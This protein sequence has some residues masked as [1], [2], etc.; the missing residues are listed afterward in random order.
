MIDA[1]DLIVGAMASGAAAGLKVA[2]KDTIKVAYAKLRKLITKNEHIESTVRRLEAK[3]SDADA[4]AALHKQ[5]AELGLEKRS[6]ARKA[7]TDVIRSVQDHAPEAGVEA[8]VDLDDLITKFI[9]LSDIS[10]T[11]ATAVRVRRAK[12]EEGITIRK[13][14]AGGAVSESVKKN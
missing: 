11:G 2:A 10:S 7:A 12:V 8:A 5:V 14:R 3:P 1:T 13:V 4:K 6:P 9:K